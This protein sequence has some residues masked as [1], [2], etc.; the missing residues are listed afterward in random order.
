MSDEKKPLPEPFRTNPN[1]TPTS[2]NPPLK[3][4]EKPRVPGPL[5]M[6]SDP[7]NERSNE[8]D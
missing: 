7:V 1:P 4:W 5:K 2:P 3:E 6:P 8:E